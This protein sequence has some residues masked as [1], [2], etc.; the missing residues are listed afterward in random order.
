M[1]EREREREKECKALASY[2]S[3]VIQMVLV[4]LFC[5]QKDECNHAIVVIRS[6]NLHAFLA[7]S[8]LKH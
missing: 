7:S 1:S 4:F 2:A 3:D 6:Q 5:L 8:Y